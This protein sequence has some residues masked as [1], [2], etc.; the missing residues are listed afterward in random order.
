[1]PIR[2]RLSW[3]V[4]FSLATLV[5]T[6]AH[7]L[8]DF[9]YGVPAR[10]GLRVTVAAAL[11]AAVYLIQVGATLLIVGTGARRRWALLVTLLIGLGWTVAVLADHWREILFAHPYREGLISKA[12]EIAVAVAGA[13]LAGSSIAAL[14]GRRL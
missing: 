7:S 8:E 5:V 6:L 9:A 1:M 11:L 14:R 13:C 4:A 3:V 10:F 12:L 2:S